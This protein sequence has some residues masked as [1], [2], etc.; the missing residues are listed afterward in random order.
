MKKKKEITRARKRTLSGYDS[1]LKSV[2]KLIDEA[3][4]T[5]VRTVDAIMTATYWEIGRRIVEFEQSGKRRAAYGI[6]L[7]KRLSNDL[8]IQFGK[9]FSERNLELMRRFYLTWPISQTLSAKS[10]ST[11]LPIS[12]EI[13]QTPSAKSPLP[14]IGK[15]FPLPLVG[16]CPSFI[17]KNT[18]YT[19]T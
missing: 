4:H 15:Y 18:R 16:L 9:G 6:A 8:T 7:L 14:Q 3:R 2:I 10:I 17:G 1:V 11:E 19:E 13:S 5:S 12:Y